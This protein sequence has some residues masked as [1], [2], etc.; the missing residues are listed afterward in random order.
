MIPLSTVGRLR[1]KTALAIAIVSLSGVSLSRPAC[2]WQMAVAETDATIVVTQNGKPVVTYNKASPPCPSGVDPV[3]QR[4]GCLHPIFSPQGKAVTEMFPADKPHQHG[5]FS[6]W[7]NATFDD[8]SV[9]CWNLAK[10]TG[11]VRHGRV[12]S[13]STQDD[14]AGFD[15]ELVHTATGGTEVDLLVERWNVTVWKTDR[16]WH[17]FDIATTQTAATKKP[18]IV[19]QHH[20][21]GM[22]FRGPASWLTD[23]D[24]YARQHPELPRVKSD[25][26][27]DRGHDRRSGNQQP[28]NWVA[29]VAGNGPEAVTVAVLGHPKNFRAPQRVRLHPTKPYCCF[30]PCSTGA[31]TI[32][33]D[34][35][36]WGN[37]RFFIA[38]GSLRPDW[39]DRQ[40]QAWAVDALQPPVD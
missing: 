33:A 16:R 9:D 3:F 4:S 5:V 10:R 30:A 2:G 24:G 15:V 26:L 32:T 18:L 21:G 37:Y 34:Q 6:A 7:V 31:F 13:T 19:N 40:W 1:L 25:F 29:L 28:A 22:A 20:Y 23:D 39:L 14:R 8:R 27:T 36:L 17:C 12:V 35:P 38:D 11:R